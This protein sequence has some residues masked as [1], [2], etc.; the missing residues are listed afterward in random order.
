MPAEGVGVTIVGVF[1]RREDRSLVEIVVA[2]AVIAAVSVAIV[3]GED[4]G[5]P[6]VF[7][8][9]TTLTVVA[10]DVTWSRRF[11]LE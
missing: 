1:E 4:R 3:G 5:F 2:P 8:V 7:D 9:C 10:A 11:V 6:E